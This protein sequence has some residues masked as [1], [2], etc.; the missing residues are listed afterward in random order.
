MRASWPEMGGSIPSKNPGLITARDTAREPNCC[1]MPTTRRIEEIDQLLDELDRLAHAS[2]SRETL[3]HTLLSRVQFLLGAEGICLFHKTS[4]EQWVPVANLGSANLT[5]T[6]DLLVAAQDDDN[7]VQSK[8]HRLLAVPIRRFRWSSGALTVQLSQVLTVAEIQD[9][10]NLLSA[11]CEILSSSHLSELESLLDRKLIAAQNSLLSVTEATSLVE[12]AYRI[13]NDLAAAVEADRVSLV[14]LGFFSGVRTLAISGVVTPSGKPEAMLAIE[15]HC[16]QAIR[17]QR[18]LTNYHRGEDSADASEEF[19]GEDGLLKNRVCIPIMAHRQPEH[20]SSNCDTSILIEW[21]DYDAFLK[22]CNLLNHLFPAV[23]LSW[24]NLARW[25]RVPRMLRWFSEMRS[26]EFALGFSR[27]LVGLFGLLVLAVAALWLVHLPTALRME[28]EGTLQP[29]EKR[30]VFAPLDGFVLRVFVSDGDHVVAGDPL[31]QLKSPQLE[32]E[33]Q[34]VLGEIRA[35]GEKRDGLSIAIN[36][37]RNA[38]SDLPMQTKIASEIRELETR[39]QTLQEKRDALFVQQE[40]LLMTAPI[41]GTVVARQI[42]RSLDARPVRRGDALLRVVNLEGPWQLE[43]LL[44]DRDA[45][46]V[47]RFLANSSAETDNSLAVEPKR[48]IEFALAS[49]PD[50]RR[51]AQVAWISESARNPRGDGMFIDV[52]ADVDQEVSHLGHMGATVNAYF[53]CGE[54]P[55]WFVWSRPLIEA[56]QRKLWF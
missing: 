54:E 27:R 7:Y 8:G 19:T 23:S 18:P 17:E 44:A 21:A 43:L 50:Q 48:Q 40:S 6:L 24:L 51:S 36:Q 10:A 49:T 46:Y 47:K 2:T 3:I 35:N 28:A 14:K 38:N 55:I 34:E 41:E 5:A 11:F 45:G 1:E 53:H 25:L 26:P 9:V 29:A 13:V 52:F 56:V 33:I 31:V 12:G 22:G 30:A 42:E 20:V 37:L 32:I 15:Q 4:G 39:L 16:Q